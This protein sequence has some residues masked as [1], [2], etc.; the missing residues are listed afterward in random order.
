MLFYCHAMHCEASELLRALLWLLGAFDCCSCCCDCC[1]KIHTKLLI[2]SS[3]LVSD[4]SLYCMTVTTLLQAFPINSLFTQKWSPSK[5]LPERNG[6]WHSLGHLLK[7]GST[8]F[9]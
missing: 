3:T 1:L 7:G 6:E 9:A 4:K 5:R 8:V 2:T